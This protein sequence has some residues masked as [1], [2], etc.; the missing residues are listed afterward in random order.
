MPLLRMDA[1]SRIDSERGGGREG[2]A[3]ME[4]VAVDADGLWSGD[5]FRGLRLL[6]EYGR[7]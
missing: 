6:S 2:Y 1:I 4:D 7:S 5:L 3:R